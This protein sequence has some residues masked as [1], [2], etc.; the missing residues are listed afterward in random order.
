MIITTLLS[1]CSQRGIIRAVTHHPRELKAAVNHHVI[2]GLAGVQQ[3]AAARQGNGG[4]APQH[5]GRSEGQQ[6]RETLLQLRG[7]GTAL[8][9]ERG[10]EAPNVREDLAVLRE[11][12]DVGGG[13]GGE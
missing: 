7:G 8:R 10:V 4:G 2:N 13:R 12:V 9:L 11:A 6:R 5:V 1:L 3:V